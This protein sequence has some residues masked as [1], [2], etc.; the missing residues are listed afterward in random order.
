MPL[1]I[2]IAGNR[3]SDTLKTILEIT[4]Y[5]V[6]FISLFM[7]NTGPIQTDLYFNKLHRNL[8]IETTA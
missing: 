7:S 3:G 2:I 5:Q 4:F 1:T 6:K 8:L